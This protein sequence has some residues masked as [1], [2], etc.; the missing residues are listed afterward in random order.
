M[1]REFF[2]LL[3]DKVMIHSNF[4]ELTGMTRL[5]GNDLKLM[6]M[7]MTKYFAAALA[8]LL[9]ISCAQKEDMAPAQ[10]AGNII[11]LTIQTEYPQAAPGTKVAFGTGENPALEWTGN[12]TAS[13][14][15]GKLV[16]TTSRETGK[17]VTLNS[18]PGKPGVFAGEVD[19]GE[20]T[21]EDIH[22]L[23]VP[24]ENNA[25][26][27][28]NNSSNRINMILPDVQ[29]Q[30]E[31]GV[32]NP[33]HVPFVVEINAA[34]LGAADANN[35]Y[36]VSG[37]QLGSASD[38]LQFNI[39]GKHS[40]MSADEVLESIKVTA[41]NKITGQT[42]LTLGQ[43]GLGSAG[44]SFV[45]VNYQGT[46][47]I[48]ERT[49]DNG[50]KVYASV[51]LGGT[52]KFTNIEVT[53]NKRTYTKS[54][55]KSIDAL[56]EISTLNVHRIGIDLST[57]NA[58]GGVLYSSD[59]GTSWGAEL[60]ETLDGR[61]AV[62]TS[63]GGAVADENLAQIAAL[64]AG[65]SKAV[66]LDMSQAEYS[67]S[68]FPNVFAGTADAPNTTLKSIKFPSNVTE[69][70]AEAFLYCSAM[71]SVD[72]TGIASIGN[73]AFRYC[74]LKTLNVPNTL[75]KLGTY[76]FADNTSL[77]SVYFDAKMPDTSDKT[78]FYTFYITS[79]EHTTDLTITV[80]PS[81]NSS[82]RVP[83]TCFRHNNNLKELVV[84]NYLI[85]RNYAL[86]ECAYL[87]TIRCKSTD[88]AV[89][90]KFACGTLWDKPADNKLGTNVQTKQIVVPAG[91][92]D[93]YAANAMIAKIVAD[94]GYEIVEE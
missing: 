5:S 80:G 34:T 89:I 48:A 71:E 21:V 30:A 85:M 88:E 29:T 65:Q 60:P 39:Y 15:I 9:V 78:N 73:S 32:F 90:S 46:E 84:E 55:E 40:M 56:T 2:A 19:L 76:I 67:S 49:K 70:A 10:K 4:L 86:R 25:Y 43:T 47:T 61:L 91:C 41:N 57:F 36:S 20:F 22:G 82:Y 7:K 11:H 92:A 3:L 27:G 68:I 37:L 81:I 52:R 87:E 42:R 66:E 74:G 17:Q 16:E 44:S 18:V 23:V 64:I 35:S 14:L 51:I 13:V 63:A 6:I 58:E 54:I 83:R 12:E 38:L 53:T 77:S 1:R 26:F 72:L 93:K 8:S 59:N 79:S 94:A 33:A 75:S 45:Q 50:I 69:V 28:Y 24:A 31:N 62:K